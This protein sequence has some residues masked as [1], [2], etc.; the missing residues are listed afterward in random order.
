MKVI[1]TKYLGMTAHVAST[2]EKEYTL[3]EVNTLWGTSPHTFTTD[4][5]DLIL[6]TSSNE[7]IRAIGYDQAMQEAQAECKRKNWQRIY[8]G[9][10]PSQA[11]S[12][13]RLYY[14]FR[15]VGNFFQLW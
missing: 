10:T 4:L 8:I 9:D 6:V 2:E 1:F 7:T 3:Q 11:E 5:G 15:Q 12:E 13:G 14:Y